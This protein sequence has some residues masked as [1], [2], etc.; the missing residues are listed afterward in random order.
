MKNTEKKHHFLS[1]TCR[2]PS[3][4]LQNRKLLLFKVTFLLGVLFL[5]VGSVCPALAAS[6]SNLPH[7][8]TVLAESSDVELTAD[9]FTTT[10]EIS[11]FHVQLN[12]AIEEHTNNL[13]EL[14]TTL[15][16]E[17][18]TLK[19]QL[20]SM[21]DDF[22]SHVK[23]FYFPVRVTYY[24]PCAYCSG[25]YT[26][27]G[28]SPK[29]GHTLATDSRIPFGTVIMIDTQNTTLQPCIDGTPIGKREFT[30]EDRGGAIKGAHFDIFVNSHSEALANGTHTVY[31][32]IVSIPENLSENDQKNLIQ[33]LT[34][35]SK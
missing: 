35:V 4:R 22:L 27:S 13:M 7:E 29:A 11:P 17:N 12:T 2:T 25:P 19:N 31:C 26:A 3:S 18:E 1:D 20:S 5:V 24:C 21:E 32:K 33:F 23:D 15:E 14:T 28:A 30:V 8:P 6:F 9:F 34:Q 10:D 16:A